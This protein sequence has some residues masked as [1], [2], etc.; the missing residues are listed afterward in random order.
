MPQGRHYLAAI[1]IIYGAFGTAVPDQGAFDLLL[2]HSQSADPFLPWPF[3]EE[4]N[5]FNPEA[6]AQGWQLWLAG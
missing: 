4:C 5:S 2:Q 1:F 3:G 6:L